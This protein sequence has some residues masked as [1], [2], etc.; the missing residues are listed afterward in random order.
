MSSRLETLQN[1]IAQD[2]SNAFARYGLAMEYSNQGNYEKAVCE[3]QSLIENKPD[4]CAAYFHCGQ[5]LEKMGNPEQAAAMYR[6][7]IDAATRT[8]DAHTRSELEGALALLP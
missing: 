7:G 6:V 3:F 4:Y 5:T 1:M 2:P 8:G